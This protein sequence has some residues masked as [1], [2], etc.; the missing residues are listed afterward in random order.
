MGPD[1]SR[2]FFVHMLQVMLKD[3]GIQVTKT[4]LQT[5][6]SFVEEVCP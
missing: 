1:H 3:W 2:Q 6:L 5:F 4:K